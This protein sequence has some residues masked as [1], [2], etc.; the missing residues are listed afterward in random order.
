MIC[1]A[2]FDKAHTQYKLVHDGTGWHANG[3]CGQ[4]FVLSYLLCCPW[5]GTEL[6]KSDPAP[7]KPKKHA[8]AEHMT[9]GIPVKQ[10]VHGQ[11]TIAEV[12]EA[13]KE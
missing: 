7:V 12:I 3:C 11:M 10:R 8:P 9:P 5:C 4:C 1:C 13:V 6:L 2:S